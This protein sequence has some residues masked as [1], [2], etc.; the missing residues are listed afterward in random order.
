MFGLW[1]WDGGILQGQSI[2]SFG[3]M[4]LR[5]CHCHWI[6]EGSLK[7]DH[8]KI[9]RDKC[10]VL[11]FPPKENEPTKKS[12]TANIAHFG[13]AGKCYSQEL[14][15]YTKKWGVAINLLLYHKLSTR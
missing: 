6:C 10:G 8:R 14:F 5:P 1:V 11:M 3:K 2:S 12:I 7:K 15:Q 13:K 4:V 9:R